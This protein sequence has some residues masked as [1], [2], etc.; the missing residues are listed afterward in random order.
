MVI[1]LLNRKGGVG[2][3]TLAV[4]IGVSLA[5][6]GARVLLI[7]ADPHGSALDWATAR[8]GSP[9]F[10]VIGLPRATLHRDMNALINNY[11]HVLIDGTPRTA[12]I[13]RSAILAADRVIVPSP[14]LAV[15]RMGDPRGRRAPL[16]SS[17]LQ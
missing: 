8:N 7:D 4:N 10:P 9:L 12:D 5:R 2:K 16:G 14:T 6:I 3:T 1:V 11:V 15:R 13:A 17:C